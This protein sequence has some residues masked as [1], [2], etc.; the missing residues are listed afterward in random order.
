V[1]TRL[2]AHEYPREIA[3]IDEL[4]LTTTG[5]IIRRELRARGAGFA[6]AARLA[7]EARLALEA[8][9]AVLP[10]LAVEARL[11]VARLA[12]EPALAALGARRAFG[13]RRA[14]R[15]D[16]PG[17]VRATEAASPAASRSG[18]ASRAAVGPAP[19]GAIIAGAGRD[20]GDAAAR[21][22]SGP[23]RHGRRSV[24]GVSRGFRLGG[25][26]PARTPPRLAS[27]AFVLGGHAFRRVASPARA[28]DGFDRRLRPRSPRA[29]RRGRFGFRLRAA[30]GLRHGRVVSRRCG[31]GSGVGTFPQAEPRRR[32][33][34]RRRSAGASPRAG[35]SLGCRLDRFGGRLRAR[36]AR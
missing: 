24:G 36:A 19:A 25:R 27:A 17:L 4:P 20:D 1:R 32:P 30:R 33:R 10:A 6:V 22:R 8:R 29:V 18:V 16:A 7:F 31:R 2:S 34:A 15:P 11:A 14:R 9:L 28:A 13:A 26:V 23:L 5:K 3:F 12:V 21:P 35:S